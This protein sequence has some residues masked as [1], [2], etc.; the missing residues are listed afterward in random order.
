MAN[1]N[2]ILEIRITISEKSL[3]GSYLRKLLVAYREQGYIRPTS[4]NNF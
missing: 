1:I 2:Q 3:H 4:N